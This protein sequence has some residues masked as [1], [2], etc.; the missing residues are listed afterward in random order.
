MEP[1]NLVVS[2][3]LPALALDKLMPLYVLVSAEGQ[4]VS[5]GPTLAKL[6]NSKI[7][8]QTADEP[9]DLV[10]S[11]LFDVFDVRRPSGVT[12]MADLMAREGERL[13][14]SLR[15]SVRS[16]VFRGV[17]LRLMEGAGML[18]N[19]SFGIGL[20]DAVRS[21]TL[22]DSDFAPTDLA[23]EMMFLVEAKSA[24]MGELTN[25][26]GRLV[27]SKQQA[28][29]QAATDALT[30]LRNRRALAMV[31]DALTADRAPYGM[32]HID[33]D[34]FKSVNDSFGH[35][36]G[37]AVLKVVARVLERETRR[38]DTVVRIGGDEFVVVCP[39]M[40][41]AARL[42]RIARRIIEEVSIPIDFDG[43]ECRISASIG[44]VTTCD[45]EE[46]TPGKM[47]ADA[48]AGL[49]ASKRAG[50]GQAHHLHRRK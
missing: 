40:T 17:A 1:H 6:L 21:F 22:T 23:V 50:R 43:Q 15:H 11:W 31:L 25:L 5:Y 41:D 24:A 26:T 36:A 29:D 37:D 28:E 49:Y 45:Y 8:D 30:G 4:I 9:A 38:D 14:L 47:Q 34:Y 18:L 3:T 10:G 42:D 27:G 20:V 19:L 13:R 16:M 44:I 46:P 48:D 33:L 2:A 35:A 12:T 32:M 7:L 39:G